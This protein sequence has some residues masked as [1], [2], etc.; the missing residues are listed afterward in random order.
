MLKGAPDKRLWANKFNGIG[1]HIEPGE[2]VLSAAW[3]ELKEE[4]GLAAE[5]VDLWL[6][7]TIIIHTGSNPGVGIYIFRGNNPRGNVRPSREG[8]LAWLPFSELQ[9]QPLV[10]D[11]H[12]LLPRVLALKRTE[13][14]LSVLY[15][16]DQD[17]QLQISFGN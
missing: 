5:S 15:S 3:R 4:T 8:R 12:I 10:E 13:P 14:P 1:G 11:L 7:G 6:C 9:S 17:D 2:D 16:Y